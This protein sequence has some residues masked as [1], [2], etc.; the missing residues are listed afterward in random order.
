[1]KQSVQRLHGEVDANYIVKLVCTRGG[2]ALP[3]STSV[4]KGYPANGRIYASLHVAV[5]V[6]TRDPSAPK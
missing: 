3:S 2:G 5:G 4:V 6:V 1:M